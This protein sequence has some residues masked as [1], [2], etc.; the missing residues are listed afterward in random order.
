[1]AGVGPGKSTEG[2]DLIIKAVTKQD[3]RP[4]YIVINAGSNTLAQ[5]I[6]DYKANHSEEELA[7]FIGKLRV[8]E[9]GAQ[10]N[11]GAWVCANYPNIHWMRSNYQTYCYGGPSY[12]SKA[13]SQDN[14]KNLGPYTWEP[15]PYSSLGQ[16][17]WALEHIKGNHGMLG[18]SWPIRQMYNGRIGYLEGGGTIPWMMLIHNGLS[19]IN[20]PHWGGW[21]GRFT[22]EKVKNEWSRSKRI[23]EEEKEF[24]D[25]WL[26]SETSDNWFNTE[27]DSL[28]NNIYTPVWRWRRAMYN[29][30]RCRMDWCVE[31]F[32]SANHNPVAAINGDNE[33]RIHFVKVKP[34]EK[35]SFDASKSSDPDGDK[36][37]FKW[38]IYREA[39]SYEK[40][41]SIKESSQSKCSVSIPADASGKTIH[42]ILEIKDNNKIA[43]LYDYR[44]IV[45]QVSNTNNHMDIKRQWNK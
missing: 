35:I 32:E 15:Y 38:W 21:S 25:F 29:D 14:D 19:D 6:F 10:D 44:R 5:A 13:G 12:K 18:K 24:N 34:G 4:V 7:S 16:H 8:F 45:I 2:S 9:N 40:E 28:M 39:G 26:Y 27:E 33:E 1:M 31:E 20:K 42:L 23:E 36:L 17:Q 22:K 30:F 11:A 3:P 37:N 43:S 41:L